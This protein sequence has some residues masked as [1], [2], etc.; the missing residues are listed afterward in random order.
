[1]TTA[2]KGPSK[3]EQAL[4]E[5]KLRLSKKG[6]TPEAFYRTV[7]TGYKKTITVE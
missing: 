1:M 6:L 7:D 4:K 2:G 5:F 3:E